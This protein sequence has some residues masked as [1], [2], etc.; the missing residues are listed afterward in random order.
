M[1][2]ERWAA[3]VV[4]VHVLHCKVGKSRRT[5]RAA[6]LSKVFSEDRCHPRS[7]RTKR[8][9]VGGGR[10]GITLYASVAER[11]RVINELLIIIRL[12]F[13]KFANKKPEEAFALGN[14]HAGGSSPA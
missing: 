12:N 6:S 1:K 4:P 9:G 14:R 8:R 10:L 7:P 13:R 5:A 11:R 2:V 3:E